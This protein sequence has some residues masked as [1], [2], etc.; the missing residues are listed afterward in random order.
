MG[1]YPH[2]LVELKVLDWVTY[3]FKLLPSCSLRMYSNCAFDEEIRDGISL[4][5]W[6]FSGKV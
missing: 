4:K 3:V 1:N 2:K 6:D 5:K